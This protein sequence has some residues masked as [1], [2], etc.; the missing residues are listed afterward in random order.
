MFCHLRVLRRRGVETTRHMQEK[1]PAGA[2]R[3]GQMSQ[4]VD[5]FL[6]SPREGL[7]PHFNEVLTLLNVPV[8]AVPTL[9]TAVMIAIAIPAAI[10]P[11][12]IAVAPD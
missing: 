5:F 10:K 11:Y 7:R 3:Q 6:V 1:D 12:S 8:R 9:F 2:I 4:L